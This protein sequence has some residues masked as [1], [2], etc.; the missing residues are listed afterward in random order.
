[1]SDINIY[2]IGFTQKSAED[3]FNLLISN[4]IKK[5]VD[6]R[7]NNS[8]QLAG[9]TKGRDLKYFLSVIG[10]IEYIHAPEY[11]PSKELLNDYKQKRIE[12]SIYE[13]RYNELL[14]QRQVIS[15]IDFAD[16]HN[17]CLLCSESTAEYCHRRLFV[18]YL[19]IHHSTIKI[20][21]L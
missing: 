16:F 7:L 19:K 1:M 5:L 20:K 14:S 12:W 2:T 18:E 9:F 15:S 8:S 3:F 21:H 13:N 4:H 17:A 6:I 10:N 11:A